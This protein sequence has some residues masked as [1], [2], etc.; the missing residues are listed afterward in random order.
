MRSNGYLVLKSR[1]VGTI[2]CRIEQRGDVHS[3]YLMTMG[4]LAV[5]SI[6]LVLPGLIFSISHTDH[7]I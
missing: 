2:C 3:L 1:Q 4:V 7:A 6:P 5:N